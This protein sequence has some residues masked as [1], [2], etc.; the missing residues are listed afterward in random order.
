M[1]LTL[2]VIYH[3]NTTGKVQSKGKIPVSKLPKVLNID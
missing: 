3:I 2:W 1:M